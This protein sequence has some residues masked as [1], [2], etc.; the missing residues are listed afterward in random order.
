MPNGLMDVPEWFSWEN[1]GAGVAVADLDGDGALD[2]VLL[3]VDNVPDGPNRGLYR[4]GKTLNADGTVTGGWGP[5][6]DV[7]EWF[8]WENQGAGVAVADLDGDGAL[9]L[10]LLMVDNVPDGPNRGLYRVGKTLN[11]DGTVTGGWAPW[12]D[13]PEWFSWENQGAGVAVADLD[14]DGALDLVLLMVDNPPQQNQGFYQLG[15]GL[16][17]NGQVASWSG[18]LGIPRWHSWEN[19]GA[20]VATARIGGREHLVVILVDAPGGKN[21]GQLQLLDL[22]VDPAVQGQWET[23]PYLSE[24]LGVHTA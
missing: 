11:A 12:I 3:M 7:P 22:T 15:R 20:D 19:Q 4:V 23:L 5:W 24:V 6:I 9:D 8:S 14:G 13:V 21:T 10:V 18:W 17:G 1:Q 2:L 16:E